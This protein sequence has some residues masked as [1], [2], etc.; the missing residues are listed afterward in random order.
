MPKIAF[1]CVR[2]K[3]NPSVKIIDYIKCQLV[4]TLK[5]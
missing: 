4:E 3:K 5:N 2:K 1:S